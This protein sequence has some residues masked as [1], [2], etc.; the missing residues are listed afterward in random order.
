MPEHIGDTFLC[1]AARKGRNTFSKLSRLYSFKMFVCDYNDIMTHRKA[2][3]PPR[4]SL[5]ALRWTRRNPS[6]EVYASNP[7]PK[8]PVYITYHWKVFA[9][10]SAAD[11]DPPIGKTPNQTAHRFWPR[12]SL[13][14]PRNPTLPRVNATMEAAKFQR[15]GNGTIARVTRN[16]QVDL[17][18]SERGFHPIVGI[19]S[20]SDWLGHRHTRA[21]PRNAPTAKADNALGVVSGDGDVEQAGAPPLTSADPIPAAMGTWLSPVCTPRASGT[22]RAAAVYSPPSANRAADP[23]AARRVRPCPDSPSSRRIA[24]SMGGSAWGPVSGILSAC[25]RRHSGTDEQQRQPRVMV[26]IDVTG[27]GHAGPGAENNYLMVSC[28]PET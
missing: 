10:D 18:P 5:R 13:Q 15:K 8:I 2:N 7:E 22:N 9:P 20:R 3:P 19:R 14:F 16:N 26:P 1:R 11:L 21:C 17:V 24:P 4:F 25:S 28:I 6:T 12:T 27:G 23:R